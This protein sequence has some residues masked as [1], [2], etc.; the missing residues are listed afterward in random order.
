MVAE[1]DK[2]QKDYKEEM[3]KLTKKLAA[4]VEEH[5]YKVKVGNI[6]AAIYEREKEIATE[7][8]LQKGI[9]L[10]TDLQEELQDFS[11][12][13]LQFEKT[14]ETKHGV[15][16]KQAVVRKLAELNGLIKAHKCQ[17]TSAAL[18]NAP[19][20]S[21]D[22]A[23]GIQKGVE[24]Y[25]AAKGNNQQDGGNERKRRIKKSR[26]RRTKRRRT[27]R[28]RTKRRRTKRRRTRASR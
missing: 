19:I 7:D 15:S 22:Q 6:R 17:K 2:Q 25:K 4:A 28:R 23:I 10:C 20:E 5:E 12:L 16:Q 26:K 3:Q 24:G 13:E 21:K 11:K 14:V 18:R 8:Q 27:K 1:N 9:Q